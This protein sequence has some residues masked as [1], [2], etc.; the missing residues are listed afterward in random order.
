MRFFLLFTMAF[1]FAFNAN[2]VV[3]QS[4]SRALSYNN[5]AKYSPPKKSRIQTNTSHEAAEPVEVPST[6]A[7]TPATPAAPQNQDK[8]VDLTSAY[9]DSITLT[10]G[11]TV[12]VKVLEEDCCEWR[13]SYNKSILTLVGNKLNQK[14]RVFTFKYRMSENTQI[15]L[16]S[17][18]RESGDYYQNK[19]LD[20]ISE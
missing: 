16:D 7:S 4:A 1:C 17:I 2:A 12:T 14:E 15:A 19:L 6:P 5:V 11:A 20:I 10:K 9:S 18:K 8:E 13:I 3:I